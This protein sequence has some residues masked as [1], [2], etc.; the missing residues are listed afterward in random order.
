MYAWRGPLSPVKA[1]SMPLLPILLSA[2]TI[3]CAPSPEQ[4][5]VI[6][7]TK[8]EDIRDASIMDQAIVRLSN[9][10]TECVQGKLAPVS[11]CSCLYPQELSGVRSAYERT[12][13]QHPDWKNKV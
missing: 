9:K 6:Q 4:G 2:S 3:C 13:R 5:E 8:P 10:V 11:E 1:T 7:L 12:I